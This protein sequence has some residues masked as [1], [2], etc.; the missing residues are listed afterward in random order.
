MKPFFTTTLGALYLGDCRSI[1]LPDESVNCVVT[2]PPYWSQRD[3]KVEPQVWGGDSSCKH[4]WA[5]T[6]AQGGN[7]SGTS[8]RRD[9]AAGRCRGETQPG[10][11]EKCGAWSGQLGLEPTPWL[12]V[13]HLVEVFLEVWRVLRPDGVVWVNMAD[14]YCTANFAFRNPGGTKNG[15]DAGLIDKGV[16]P[17]DSP[18]RRPIP[19]LKRK[20]MALVPARL[21]IALQES[22]WWVRQNVI[23]RKPN[24]KPENVKDRPVTCHEHVFMLTKA[25]RYWYDADAIREPYTGKPEDNTPA[26]LARAFSS[27]RRHVPGN[28]QRGLDVGHQMPSKWNNPRCKNRRSVWDIASVKCPV[29]HYSA[30]PKA[31]V[32]ICLKAGTPPGGMVLDPFMGSGTVAEVAERMNLSWVGMELS[33]E[34]ALEALKRLET[35]GAWITCD[36][37]LHRPEN[38]RPARSEEVGFGG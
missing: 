30:F 22:G 3:Y 33:P 31:L 25:A 32:E 35:T 38:G 12:F 9:K 34:S 16:I 23:W 24:V 13:E 19:G 37:T 6:K 17:L 29:K 10:F 20:D 11:C 27:K 2:S 28:R 7:G 8:S 26:D 18:A 1:P 36:S 14:T 5:S 21:S 4:R 15:F